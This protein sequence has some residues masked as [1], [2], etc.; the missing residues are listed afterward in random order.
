MEAALQYALKMVKYSLCIFTVK[1][2]F[3]YRE[4]CELPYLQRKY[5]FNKAICIILRQMVLQL[6]FLF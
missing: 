3:F 1:Y 5:L 2:R 6:Y 4:N